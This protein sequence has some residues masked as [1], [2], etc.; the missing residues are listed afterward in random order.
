MKLRSV[1]SFQHD[2]SVQNLRGTVGKQ[3]A[4]HLETEYLSYW[5]TA[6]TTTTTNLYMTFCFP[7]FFIFDTIL[8]NFDFFSFEIFKTDPPKRIEVFF[9]VLSFE[10]TL[11]TI[12]LNRHTHTNKSWF[13][14]G[15][16]ISFFFFFFPLV[17][18]HWM[19]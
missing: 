19:I 14:G 13:P 2:A 6:Q 17:L 15:R 1:G 7:F 16:E 11:I 3:R 5:G 8:L 12:I 10:I 18:Y 9:H 4:S